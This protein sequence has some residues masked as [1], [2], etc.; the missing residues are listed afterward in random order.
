MIYYTQ[1]GADLCL[2]IMKFIN[3]MTALFFRDGWNMAKNKAT[4]FGSWRTERSTPANFAM[5]F[6]MDPANGNFPMGG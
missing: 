5:I 3:W 6:P 4:A 2:N 1:G